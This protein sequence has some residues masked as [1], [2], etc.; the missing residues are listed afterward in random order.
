MANIS[1]AKFKVRMHDAVTDLTIE[2]IQ[3]WYVV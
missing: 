2:W 3:K 1:G